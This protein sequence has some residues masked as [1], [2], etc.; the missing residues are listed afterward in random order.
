MLPQVV[1]L[2]ARFCTFSPQGTWQVTSESARAKLAKRLADENFGDLENSRMENASTMCYVLFV[3]YTFAC[4]FDALRKYVRRIAQHATDG[5][6]F[7]FAWSVTAWGWP[8]SSSSSSVES[9]VRARRG[10]Q[11][12]LRQVNRIYMRLGHRSRE[13]VKTVVGPPLLCGLRSLYR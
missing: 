6:I 9:W 4:E 5:I 7:R 3:A 12:G 2:N 1:L 13:S 8:W 10:K 11:S